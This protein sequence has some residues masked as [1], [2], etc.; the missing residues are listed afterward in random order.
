MPRQNWPENDKLV[1]LLVTLDIAMD[2]AEL[3]GVI[4]GRIAGAPLANEEQHLLAF[5][6]TFGDLVFT[7]GCKDV[8]KN[9]TESLMSSLSDKGQLDLPQLFPEQ[10]LPLAERLECLAA[11]CRGFI[12]GLGIAGLTEAQTQLP[13]MKEVIE[14]IQQISY[15]GLEEETDTAQEDAM[16]ELIEYVRMA[17]FMVYTTIY[18]EA[19]NQQE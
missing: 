17:P 3:Q 10:A 18:N 7:P 16:M 8:F 19:T 12:F 4:V 2:P 11:W 6:E 13:E 1:E 15:V 5:A 9:A 14:D